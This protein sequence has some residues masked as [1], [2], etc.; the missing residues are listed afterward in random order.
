M[1]EYHARIAGFDERV[2][3]GR[4]LLGFR[5]RQLTPRAGVERM[6]FSEGCVTSFLMGIYCP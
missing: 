1:P 6:G 5:E 4:Q 2:G 3:A